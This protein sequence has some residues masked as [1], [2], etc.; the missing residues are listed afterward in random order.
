MYFP[1]FSN[2]SQKS[3]DNDKFGH[4]DKSFCEI[5]NLNMSIAK[6]NKWIL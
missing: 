2:N 5:L 6:N 4:K 3:T 1:Y